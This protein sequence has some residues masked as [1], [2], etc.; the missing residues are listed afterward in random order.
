MLDLLKRFEEDRLG[1]S[2]LLGED[3]DVDD[4][5]VDDLAERL[6]GIDVGAHLIHRSAPCAHRGRVSRFPSRIQRP[7]RMMNYGVVS[8]LPSATSS[9]AR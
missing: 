9:R 7:H 6:G 4:D 8:H 5:D 2:P 3:V 1:D